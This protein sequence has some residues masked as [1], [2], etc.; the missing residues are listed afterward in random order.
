[1]RYSNKPAPDFSR[2][3][4]ALLREGIPDGIPFAEIYADR[5]II[6]AV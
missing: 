1:M 2:L 3:R 6:E 4:K 5:E